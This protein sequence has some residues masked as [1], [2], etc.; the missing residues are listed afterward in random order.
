MR[1]LFNVA[2]NYQQELLAAGTPQG[3]IDSLKVAGDSLIKVNDDQEFLK[4]QRLIKT[5]ARIQ[6]Y[7]ELWEIVI[8]VCR[9]GK[10]VYYDNYSKYKQYLLYQGA[11]NGSDILTGPV[12]A[13]RT[14]VILDENITSET[15]FKLHNIGN[16]LL[17]FCLEDGQNPCSNGVQLSPDS[18][19]IINAADLGSGTT[20]KCT[21]NSDTESGEYEVEVS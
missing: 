9:V 19:Q 2:K 10:I 5:H 21:N 3:Q 4:K 20:L 12:P 7:N 15:N 16:T 18:E 8:T 17:K 13:N 14:I 1:T 11:G 6:K